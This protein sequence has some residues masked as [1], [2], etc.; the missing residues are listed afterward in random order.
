MLKK[1]NAEN[2]KTIGQMNLE[3]SKNGIILDKLML[4]LREF[5]KM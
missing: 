1:E 2:S 5:L 4:K 3:I